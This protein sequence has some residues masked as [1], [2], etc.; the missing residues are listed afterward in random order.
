[1]LHIIWIV[2]FLGAAVTALYQSMLLVINSSSVILIPVTIFAYL[3]Q[4]GYANP[5][6]HFLPILLAASCSTI[7]GLLAVSLYQRSVKRSDSRSGR[8]ELLARDDDVLFRCN[9]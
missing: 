1:M 3:H 4:L 6:E 2:F 7:A 5:T 9:R 8:L